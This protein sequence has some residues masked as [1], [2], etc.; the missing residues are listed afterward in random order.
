MTVPS[1]LQNNSASVNFGSAAEAIPNARAALRPLATAGAIAVILFLVFYNLPRYPL[2]WF[3]EGS[4]LHVPKSVLTRGVYA[5]YSSDGFRY[6]GPT[7]GVGPTVLLPIAAA[8]WAFGIGLLQARI[9]M[10]LYLL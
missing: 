10:A 1:K 7:V 9:V 5:D 3:D 6:F 2:T 8:F 4:H